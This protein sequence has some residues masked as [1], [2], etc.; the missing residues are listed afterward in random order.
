MKNKDINE[1]L[2]DNEID[3]LT[4]IQNKK[5][6]TIFLTELLEMHL[7]EQLQL[8]AVSRRSEQLCGT[9]TDFKIE[10]KVFVCKKC[11][12]EQKTISA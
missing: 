2:L 1:W 7:T 3:C 12:K 10:G 8:Y 6:E 11:G 4:T 5:R 9:C